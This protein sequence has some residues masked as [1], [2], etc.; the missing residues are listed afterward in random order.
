MV[1][2]IHSA[3]I[4]FCNIFKTAISEG[5]VQCEVGL[6]TDIMKSA[7][8]T[9]LTSYRTYLLFQSTI[10]INRIQNFRIQLLNNSKFIDTLVLQ[11]RMHT[12]YF[13]P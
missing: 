6:S 13:H 7:A 12:T 5:D 10:E 8:L 3:R 9:K 4:I 2:N 11:P 1:Q